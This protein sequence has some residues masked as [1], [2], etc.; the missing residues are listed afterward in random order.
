MLCSLQ[1]ENHRLA[2]ELLLLRKQQQHG[3]TRREAPA[4][5][6]P[7]PPPASA[8]GNSSSSSSKCDAGS[9]TTRGGGGGGGFE[10]SNCR[11][12]QPSKAGEDKSKSESSANHLHAHEQ[13]LSVSGSSTDPHAALD[14][15]ILRALLH[16]GQALHK[17]RPKIG[18][19]DTLYSTVE[20]LIQEH[21]KLMRLVSA[22]VAPRCT[23]LAQVV[24]Q[25][26]AS[27][28]QTAADSEA[29]SNSSQQTSPL[30]IVPH[31]DYKMSEAH[32]EYRVFSSLVRVPGDRKEHRQHPRV[33][34]SSRWSEPGGA[35]RRKGSLGSEGGSG[36]GQGA[37]HDV[38]GD[39]LACESRFLAGAA[40]SL[41][42]EVSRCVRDR[43]HVPCEYV[44][45]KLPVV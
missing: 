16:W 13:R 17:I 23:S 40:D 30:L 26:S 38:S 43:P 32:E 44:S 41:I 20:W 1:A 33:A 11:R 39:F 36:Q 29:S 9:S 6:S 27:P 2:Q 37:E 5:S 45:D 15:E 34:H 18:P 4:R 8:S 19:G 28:Q 25:V 7:S 35:A 42:S 31:S 14:T 24:T 3:I 10:A 12:H 21:A 22:A